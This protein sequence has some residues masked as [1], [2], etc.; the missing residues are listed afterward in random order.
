MD[1]NYPPG[2]CIDLKAQLVVSTA[3]PMIIDLVLVL[4][5]IPILWKLQ[6]ATKK[7]VII[8]FI[9]ALGLLFVSSRLTLPT[10]SNLIDQISELLQ[11]RVFS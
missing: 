9:L 5:P 3:V 10:D 8:I 1:K 11:W 2:T 6:I 7:K 4:L